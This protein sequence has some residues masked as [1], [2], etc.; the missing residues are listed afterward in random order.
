MHTPAKVAENG[1]V[2][3]PM[4]GEVDVAGMTLADLES[5][6]LDDSIAHHATGPLPIVVAQYLDPDEV[7][8]VIETVT[9]NV[10]VRVAQGTVTQQMTVTKE[11]KSTHTASSSG[12]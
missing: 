5:K 2:L 7:T 4:I 9:E 6:I 12:K 3:L 8:V 1:K 10:P 11:G